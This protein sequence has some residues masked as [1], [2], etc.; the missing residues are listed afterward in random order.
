MK[1]TVRPATASDLESIFQLSSEHLETKQVQVDGSTIQITFQVLFEHPAY[2]IMVAVNPDERVVGMVTASVSPLVERSQ[3]LVFLENLFVHESARSQQVATQL[4]DAVIVDT[5]AEQ[6]LFATS[7][8]E[9]DLAETSRLFVNSGYQ[10]ADEHT[11]AQIIESL[12]EL[13][14]ERGLEGNIVYYFMT[15]Q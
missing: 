1:Y 10:K 4:M 5:S 8:A 14:L 3:T 2:Q 15:P 12:R 13:P 6:P 7:V 11:A 9:S